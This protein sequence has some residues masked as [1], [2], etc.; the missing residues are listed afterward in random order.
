MS[1]VLTVWAAE[2]STQVDVVQVRGQ[3]VIALTWILRRSHNFIV[4]NLAG[5]D[6]PGMQFNL[7]SYGSCIGARRKVPELLCGTNSPNVRH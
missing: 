3:R 1:Q 4:N 7:S 6:P 5:Y 2:T